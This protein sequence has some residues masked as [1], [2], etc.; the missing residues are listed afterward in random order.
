MSTIDQA[1]DYLADLTVG[2]AVSSHY[3]AVPNPT[4]GSGY[5][6]STNNLQV[7]QSKDGNTILLSGLYA[8]EIAAGAS[9]RTVTLNIPV[10]IANPPSSNKTFWTGYVDSY[11]WDA[12]TGGINIRNAV[13]LTVSTAGKV[14]INLSLSNNS[15]KKTKAFY[16]QNG[17]V[18]R[19]GGGN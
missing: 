12:A 4:L 7:A 1:L 15:G 9:A 16:S 10:T 8:V 2:S 3:T 19:L 11:T 13:Q 6:Q 14:T 18:Y 17:A 5:T